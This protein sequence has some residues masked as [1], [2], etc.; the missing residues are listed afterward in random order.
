M[1]KIFQEVG[2]IQDD[3]GMLIVTGTLT[4]KAMCE[5]L[6]PFR[7][8]YKL[9]DMQTLSIA[10]QEISITEIVKLLGSE[11]DGYD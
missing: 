5:L 9:T 10:R 8:K 7:D 11:G 6:I 4:K 1:S 3:Y 2:E